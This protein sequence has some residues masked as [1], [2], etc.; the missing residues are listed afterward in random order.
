MKKKTLLAVL[1]IGVMLLLIIAAGIHD[2]RVAKDQNADM[3]EWIT[4]HPQPIWVDIEYT[5]VVSL[6]MP[7]WKYK[8]T[9]QEGSSYLTQLTPM[10]L[11]DIIISTQQIYGE[12][13]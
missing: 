3:K 12:G 4:T 2:S 9:D 1:G 6:G 10:K 7:V 5:G 11:P 13:R 8:L